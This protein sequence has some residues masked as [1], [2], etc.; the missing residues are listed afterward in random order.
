VVALYS[1]RAGAFASL[2]QRLVEAAVS[3]LASRETGA[4]VSAGVR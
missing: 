1:T 2:H 4:Q 3:L